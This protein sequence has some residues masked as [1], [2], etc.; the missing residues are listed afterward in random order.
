MDRQPVLLQ[1][2]GA[3]NAPKAVIGQAI[4]YVDG[5]HEIAHVHHRAQLVYALSGSVRVITPSG[6]W[7]L[8][9]G[10]ALLIGSRIEHELQMVGRVA[11]RT[12]YINP[13]ALGGVLDECRVITVGQLLNAAISAMFETELDDE[14]GSKDTLLVPLILRLL[15]QSDAH[16]QV[17]RLPLPANPR[18]RSICTALIQQPANNDTLERWSERVHASARTLARLFRQETGMTFGQWREELRLADALSR[19]TL[20]QSV[21]DVARELGYADVRTFTVMFKRAFG[22]TAQQFKAQVV[23]RSAEVSVV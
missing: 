6:L 4:D 8:T 12:L 7:A 9:P 15:Q 1:T 10:S 5:A 19:L 22:C 20:G 14:Q 16:P 18:L 17:G 3:A 13:E 11:M 21:S 23:S 2:Y